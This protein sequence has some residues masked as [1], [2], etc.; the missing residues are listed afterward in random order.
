MIKL[1]NVSTTRETIPPLFFRVSLPVRV[2]DVDFLEVPD[3]ERPV[4]ALFDVFAVVD[5]ERDELLL[6][7]VDVARPFLLEPVRDELDRDF[8][9]DPFPERADFAFDDE[10][11]DF[12]EALELLDFDGGEEDFEREKPL[13][14]ELLTDFAWLNELLFA[15]ALFD[16][17]EFPDL[18]ETL[19]L[20][21]ADFAVLVFDEPDFE[22]LE[23]EALPFEPEEADFADPFSVFDLLPDVELFEPD[24]ELEDFFAVAILASLLG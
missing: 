1:D 6:G 23:L 18:D 13:D 11:P 14:F 20:D 4:A 5:F 3:L 9:A 2:E 22:E 19:D 17:E 16:P 21:E 12:V 24:F 15:D 7:V 8:V 10:E